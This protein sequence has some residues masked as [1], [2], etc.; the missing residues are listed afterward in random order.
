MPYKITRKYRGPEAA[1]M[2][3]CPFDC[4]HL[5]NVPPEGQRLYIDAETCTECG[6]CALACTN[7]GIVPVTAVP[8]YRPLPHHIPRMTGNL[9]GSVGGWDGSAVKDTG[10]NPDEVLHE[11]QIPSDKLILNGKVESWSDLMSATA[12]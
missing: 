7:G 8:H 12:D 2:D 3:A 6:A 1:C 11:L 9:V 5:E 4:I 10:A